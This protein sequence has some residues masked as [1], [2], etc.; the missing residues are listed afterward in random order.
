MTELVQTPWAT[1]GP[2]FHY[3]LP[4]KDGGTLVTGATQGERITIEGRI[5]DGDGTPVIDALLEI[6]QANAA[7]RYHHP[8]DTQDKPLDPAFH[9]WGRTETDADG[10]FRFETIKPGA[11]PYEGNEW[12]APH[13]NVTVLGRGILKRLVTRIY[14]AGESANDS[15]PV[16]SLVPPVRRQTLIAAKD[17]ATYRFDIVLQ[18]AGETVFF[19]L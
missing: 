5:T 3:A 10:R 14:F 1:V 18:G 19:E 8:E 13:I 12:Q 7:G 16:L 9:G 6:W 15:D 4:V 2:F 17:G 11:V